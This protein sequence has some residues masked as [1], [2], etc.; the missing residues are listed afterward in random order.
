MGEQ[1][2]E[3]GVSPHVSPQ[4]NVADVGGLIS[5]AGF[6]LPTV[7]VDDITIQYSDAFMLMDEL[8]GL[9]L[10]FLVRLMLLSCGNLG[11]LHLYRRVCAR[12]VRSND[13]LSRTVLRCKLVNTPEACSRRHMA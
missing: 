8:R 5:G 12:V 1:E 11:H 7:D 3:G 6:S 9:I 2:R 4:A 10:T 13:E